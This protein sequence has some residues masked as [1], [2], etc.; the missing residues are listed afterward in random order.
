[1]RRIYIAMI[2][3][4]G[5]LTACDKQDI[6]SFSDR[7]EIYFE[8]FYTNAIHPGTEQADSTVASFFF[9]PDGTPDI[10]AALTVLYSGIPLTEDGHFQLRVIDSLTTA[11]PEEYTIDPEYIFHAGGTVDSVNKD[12]RDVIKIKIHRSQ[13]ISDGTDVFLFLEMVPNDR[14][15]WGQIERI[16][17]RICITTVAVR[18]GWWTDEVTNN[19]LGRYSQKKYKY[20][21]NHIDKEARMNADLIKEHPDEAI[22]LTLQYKEWLMKQNPLLEDEYGVIK[23]V[24]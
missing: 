7:S 9:Y 4:V 10:E 3:L 16:R 5:V 24:L 20:F 23:V 15:V 14:L 19:L 12:I 13:R 8:K 6:G 18:P 1:M 11:S 21:L 2:I 17:A 22:Q